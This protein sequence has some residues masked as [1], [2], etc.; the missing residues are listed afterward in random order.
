MMQNLLA[1]FLSFFF[2]NSKRL[3]KTRLGFIVQ[4]M[5]AIIVFA[6]VY[7]ALSLRFPSCKEML[8]TKNEF[9]DISENKKVLEVEASM[10]RANCPK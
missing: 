3:P 2:V 7:F 8:K 5:I 10:K 9:L 6:L 4:P 1:F